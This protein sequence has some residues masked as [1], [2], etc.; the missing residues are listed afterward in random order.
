MRVR[1]TLIVGLTSA[2][3]AVS[4]CDRDGSTT[5]PPRTPPASVATAPPTPQPQRFVGEMPSLAPL[6]ESV[7]GAVVNVD[8]QSRA[9]A[10]RGPAAQDPFGFFFGGPGPGPGRGA[11]PP[12][13]QNAG[14]GFII[15]PKG[16]VLTNNH[17]VENA[18][19][20]RVRLDDGRSYDAKVL[21]R[22][23]LTD[24]A[25][26]QLEEVK[27]PLPTVLLGDSDAAKVGDYLVAIGNPFGLASS[28][29]AGILSARARDI[30]AGP[31]DDFLQTDAAINPG[32][33]GGPLFNLKGEVVGINTAI[34]GGGTGI[35]FAVPSNMAKAL[36]GQLEQGVVRRGWLGV[37]VQDLTPE[38]GD[39]LGV[40]ANEGA[41]I[42]DVSRDTPA[43]R[44]GLRADD[45]VVA[46]NGQPIDSSRELTRTIGLLMPGAEA[47]LTVLRDG[48]R[49]ELSVELGERPDYEGVGRISPASSGGGEEK[50]ERIGLS[51]RDLDP[52]MAQN[53]GPSSGALIAEVVPGSRADDAGLQPGMIIVEAGGEPVRTARDLV[54]IIGDAPS[55]KNLLVRVDVRGSRVL[56]ALPV[57]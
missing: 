21:G 53:G 4:A 24:L 55:G 43:A 50:A 13:R 8:V 22:D 16:R 39:A 45:I 6:V 23:P 37:A 47:K 51:L 28:V 5:A 26:L 36:L 48:E 1:T 3:F 32:N 57:P 54:R 46:V 44:A 27:E 49:K 10:M 25:L 9:R 35:G 20:I 18:V 7:K 29:S 2:L 42:A 11:Q 30:N 38:L 31:Y 52:R 34:I 19:A 40:E 56:R 33:S 41:V 14:S 12:V 15:D 17:V